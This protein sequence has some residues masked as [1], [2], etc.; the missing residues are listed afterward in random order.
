MKTMIEN[1]FKMSKREFALDLTWPIAVLFFLVFSGFHS[2]AQQSPVEVTVR[3]A[4]PIFDCNNQTYCLDVEFMADVADEELF[5][6]N[7]RFYYDNE[8]L[9][10]IAFGDFQGGYSPV[11]PNPPEIIPL[12][13]GGGQVSFGFSGDGVLLNGAIQLIDA[14]AGSV[15]LST[16]EWTKLFN[17]CFN[18]NPNYFSMPEF[19]PSIVWDLRA[20]KEGGFGV[21]SDGVVMTLVDYN[22]DFI[23][24]PTDEIVVQYNW[25]YSGE[26]DLP[27]GF[28]VP[29]ICSSTTCVAIPLSDWA[30]YTGVFLILTF[31]II[32]YRRLI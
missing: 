4:N 7:V 9:E 19:C 23:S 6:M 27:Y 24:K 8:V 14:N 26:P 21:G 17:V 15:F 11:N 25:E 10:F 22:R 3:F 32:R 29:E 18:V 16:T 13:S 1:K 30:L 31:L 2:F 28:P 12:V 20:D 5:G